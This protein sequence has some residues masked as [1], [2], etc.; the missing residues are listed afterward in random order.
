MGKLMSII[1]LK[2]IEMAVFASIHPL[3]S[4]CSEGVVGGMQLIAADKS[5]F[6]GKNHLSFYEVS[7]K[8]LM[9]QCG[10]DGPQ[11]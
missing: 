7:Y 2:S 10:H 3:Y 4:T 9:W 1:Q 8:T 6:M 5:V 11:I